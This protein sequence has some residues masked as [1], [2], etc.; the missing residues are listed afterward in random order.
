MSKTVNYGLYVTDD[1]SERF[2]HWRAG[3]NGETDSNM[4][5]IDTILGNKADSSLVIKTVLR[6]GAWTGTSVPFTQEISIN[7]LSSTQNGVISVDHSATAEQRDCA[8]NSALSVI[9]QLDGKLVVSADKEKPGKDIP[10]C[11][12]LLG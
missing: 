8:R 6:A 3:M 11:V 9:E 2:D 1:S 10:V 7:G 12:I 5:K 4:T